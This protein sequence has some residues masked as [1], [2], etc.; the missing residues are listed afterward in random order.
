MADH[1]LESFALDITTLKANNNN[2]EDKSTSP[3]IS[4][5]NFKSANIEAMAQ[6]LSTTDWDAVLG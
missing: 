3:E 4:N 1:N 2:L 5:F 6:A